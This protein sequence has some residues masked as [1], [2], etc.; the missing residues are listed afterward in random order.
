MR[1]GLANAW[2]ILLMAACCGLSLALSAQDH[3]PM[4]KI[5]T[6]NFRIA[7]VIV[8]KIDGHPLDRAR[9]LLRDTK[10]RQP[11]QSAV[12]AAG[13]KFAF[14]NLGAGKFSLEGVKT[15]FIGAA[16]DQHDQYSTAIV[17]G[18][19]VDTENLILK[20]SPAAIIG[21][22]VI[23]EA[24]EPV[25]Q[26][27]ITL[28]RNDHLQGADQIRTVQ[29]EQADD[30]GAYEFT[31]LSPGTYFLSVHGQPWYAVHP[32]SSSDH[33]GT[34]G[35][36]ETN[37]SVQRSLDVTYPVT[38]YENATETDEA[39]PIQIRGGEHLQFE[40]QLTP[41]PSLRLVYHVPGDPNRG[42]ALPQL[43]QPVFDGVTSLQTTAVFPSPGVVE[44]TGIPAGRYNIH[45]P[46][47]GTVTQL[48]GIELSKDGEELNASAAEALSTVRVSVT[49]PGEPSIPNNLAVGLVQAR[50]AP[51]DVR[52]LNPKGEAEID[53]VAPGEYEVQAFG[54]GKQYSIV[55]LSAEGVQ[56]KGHTLTVPAGASAKVKLTLASGID[57]QGV[58]R[59]A[60]KPFA[61]AMIVLVPKG[62]EENRDLFR[63]DQSDLDG[64]FSLHD[65]PPGSYTL[66]A[67]ENG[68]DLDWS[69]PEVIAAYVKRGTSVMVS[70]S[71][72]TVHVKE[73]VQVQPK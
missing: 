59:K 2:S 62:P 38:Y 6:A 71:S 66:V 32:P 42:F 35:N 29:S 34:E 13:G 28:Y 11:M 58:A 63:R 54:G 31:S 16:Y 68:W 21:G 41:V 48:N 27:M 70:P 25:R 64:T 47:P 18:A 15:G 55:G 5:S 37:I 26:A 49:V 19:G 51:R 24:S 9:V 73:A 43:E 65:V 12:T 14:E 61:E 3:A 1:N 67:I 17:T 57:I 8:S 45:I 7:G 39:T 69:R 60:T 40:T 33:A 20:L 22:R 23:D 10:A 46:G 53:L 30:L 52:P 72:K 44:L 50:M 36:A 4:A 56:A